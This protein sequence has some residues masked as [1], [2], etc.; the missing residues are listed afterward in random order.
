MGGV[1]YS[2]I[3]YSNKRVCSES[4]RP[5][6]GDLEA[7]QKF[8]STLKGGYVDGLW[9]SSLERRRMAEKTA[10]DGSTDALN[11]LNLTI[12]ERD[13]LPTFF[14]NKM[15]DPYQADPNVLTP[16]A[17]AMPFGHMNWAR[18]SPM[19]PFAHAQAPT[20]GNIFGNLKPSPLSR[21]KEAVVPVLP[22]VFMNTPGK[23]S[24]GSY[25]H[26][27]DSPLAPTPV[28]RGSDGVFTPTLFYGST[29]RDWGTPSWGGDDAKMLHEALSSSRSMHTTVTPRRVRGDAHRSTDRRSHDAM[30]ENS[31]YAK[32]NS[33]PRVFFKDQLTET[34][35]FMR[36]SRISL[37]VSSCMFS[38][39]LPSTEMLDTRIAHTSFS[40]THF[41][42]HHLVR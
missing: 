11:S 7:L 26:H 38:L 30:A 33:T 29:G 40:R 1:M 12:A 14:R 36:T 27:E 13:R 16:G 34:Y 15:L 19:G 24:G 8:F 3:R 23:P 21:A 4:P 28:Q 41:R 37:A 31:A 17:G 9:L 6:K 20:Q 22:A 10:G 39:A 2:G 18:P 5:T 32:S 35:N 25:R 42:R